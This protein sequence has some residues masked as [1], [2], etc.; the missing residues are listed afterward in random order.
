MDVFQLREKV[1]GEYAEYVESFVNVLDPRVDE[2]VRNSLESGDLWPDTYL[3]LNPA[4]EPG[5]TLSE[6]AQ[7]GSIAPGTAKFF[8]E[9]IRLYQHQQEALTIAQTK[10]PYVVTTGTGSGKSLTYLIP[11]YDAIVKANPSDHS[12]RAII[13]YPMNALINS[14]LDALQEYATKSGLHNIRFQKYTGDV[15][16]EARDEILADPPHILLTNYVMLE[17]MLLRPAER[18]LLEKATESLTHLVVDELHF[19]RGR[20]GSDVSM[21]L[22][23]VQQKAGHD[24]QVIGT[25]ATVAT[26]ATR[27][28]RR[29][30]IGDVASK[31]FGVAIPSYHVI[32]ETLQPLIKTEIPKGPA[33]TAAVHNAP[34]LADL[35]SVLNHPLCAWIERAFGIQESEN[36]LIRQK[37]ET[38]SDAVKRL[39]EQTG[40]DPEVCETRLKATL[41]IG[42]QVHQ[43]N[44]TEPIFAFRLHQFMSSGGSLHATLESLE[45]RTI[46]RDA[47]YKLDQDRLLFPLEF[48]RE[49]GQDYY[50]VSMITD[51]DQQKL[52]P[53]LPITSGFDDDFL[54]NSGFF[55][56]EDGDLWEGNQDDLPD[57][58]FDMLKNGPRINKEWAEFIPREITVNSGGQIGGETEGWFTKSPFVFCL[59]C[60]AV[61]GKLGRDYTKLSSLGNVGR[62]SAATITVSSM[63][64]G[65]NEQDVGKGESKT[66]SF[67]DN[68]QDAS[69]QAGHLNDFIQVSQI[70][71]ALA[72]AVKENDGL[73]FPNLG[74]AIFEAM[75]LVPSDFAEGLVTPEGPGYENARN[76]LLGVI[77]YMAIEDL[78]R[79]WR[80]TQPNLEQTGLIGIKYDGLDELASDNSKWL[81]IA[82]FCEVNVEKRFSILKAFLDHFRM[83]LAIEAEVLTENRTRAIVTQ[84]NQWLK[85]PWAFDDGERLK[86]HLMAT[87]PEYQPSYQEKRYGTVSTSRRSAIGRYLR[88]SQ[89]WGTESNFSGDEVE[90]IVKG[91]VSVLNGHILRIVNGPDNEERGFRIIADSL[92]WTSGD[93]IPV[94]PD[95]VRTRQLHLRKDIGQ[96]QANSYFKRLYETEAT[97]FKHII[98]AEHTGQVRAEARNQRESDFRSGALPVLFCS[99]TMELGVD[100]K[101]LHSVHMRNI[102]P[103]PANYAQR[104]GRAGRGG[105][106]ALIATFAAH[107]NAHD[108]YFFNNREMMI[109]GSVEPARMDLANKD[110]LEAHIHSTWL[111]AIGL[112]FGD[113][114]IEILD[115]ETPSLVIHPEIS[116]RLE[117]PNYTQ[118]LQAALQAAQE[119]IV[120]A[121]EI[122]DSWW[123][124]PEWID[125]IVKNSPHALDIAF[126]RWRE[127]YKSACNMR[128]DSRKIKDSPTAKQADIRAAEQRE[129]E[130]LRDLD[131][132]YNRGVGQDQADFYPYRYLASEG[133]IP[134]YNF[135]RLPVRT[136]I[137]VGNSSESIERYRFLGLSEFG[138]GNIVYHE[139]R[140]HRI[141][142]IV[143]PSSGID[144]RFRTAKLC[145]I[146]GYLHSENIATIELCEFCGSTLSSD[147]S[148]FPQKLLDQ[149]ATRTRVVDRISSEE[150]ERRRSGYSITTHF[151]IPPGSRT[152]QA[153]VSDEAGQPM[154]EVKYIPSATIWRINHGW[155]R[156]EQNG[157]AIDPSTGRWQRRASNIDDTQDDI[158]NAQIVTGVKPYVTD[159]R[160]LLLIKVLSDDV[161]QDFL[162]TLLYALQ[163]GIQIEYQVEE[164]EIS[165]ELIGN[166]EY[167]QLF[168]WESAEGGTGVWDRL[169]ETPNS[170]RHIAR[171][172]LEVCHIDAETGDSM[173]NHDPTSCMVACYECLLSY[174]NQAHHPLINRH[175][176][177]DFLTSMTTGSLQTQALGL[178]RSTHYRWLKGLCDPHSPLEHQFL[179]HLFY[180]GLRL[181]TTAQNRPH[182]E[183]FVQPDFYYDRGDIPG[184]CIFVDGAHHQQPVQHAHDQDVRGQLED[185]GFRVI[186][187]VG[188]LPFQDQINPHQDIFGV[189]AS[190]TPPIPSATV[191][192]E[193]GYIGQFKI[194][195]ELG[196]GGYGVVYLCQNKW[197]SG[198]QQAVKVLNASWANDDE[199]QQKFINEA[200]FQTA[201]HHPN[202][203]PISDF[204]KQDGL[205]YMVMEYCPGGNLEDYI[206]H[207]GAL[208]W[209]K[210]IQLL[211]Q[212]C[213]GLSAAH[214][215]DIIHRDLKPRNILI[216]ENENCKIT[217]FGL[218]TSLDNLPNSAVGTFAYMAPEQKA[219][220][221]TDQRADIYALGVTFYQML[222][223]SFPDEILQG[224][225]PRSP[226]EYVPDIPDFVVEALFKCLQQ[227]KKD[228]FDN[229][230]ELMAALG[231]NTSFR[232]PDQLKTAPEYIDIEKIS[233]ADHHMLWDEIKDLINE[234]WLDLAFALEDQ[235]VPVP[236]DAHRD[237]MIKDRVVGQAILCWEDE[238]RMLI[239]VDKNEA[240]SDSQNDSLEIIEIT[241][242]SNGSV[243]CTQIKNWFDS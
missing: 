165:A 130:A 140:K 12:V 80:V 222:T 100:I 181:P 60:R 89:T 114:M 178:T 147:N 23:R 14:Q 199:W 132:L 161:E 208:P 77:E 43:I 41:D 27:D 230:E 175:L 143:L 183:V 241:P 125:E 198:I 184:A 112:G 92:I 56:I 79:G 163:R 167:K 53:R 83:K 104:S 228:R 217:D 236:F 70:R 59:R 10:A 243:I 209:E 34:P 129:R 220:H 190:E 94:P 168:L 52:V 204:L 151:Q 109:S 187:I 152:R 149:P 73:R 213:D 203:V 69:L 51:N 185:L 31:L 144:E 124:G 9:N 45:S 35:D 97:R 93:G 58:W 186:S 32:D 158:H 192:D 195:S 40:L 113:S 29:K 202:V 189:P 85:K 90:N 81:E 182:P 215:K 101:E 238:L 155:R 171:K 118:Q 99:P 157:F 6:L 88:A 21:L 219:G 19:Y 150:E 156:S 179:D 206:K 38:V 162:L 4:F 87:L 49:C 239:L 134:G 174:S 169:I 214:N 164:Q 72:A 102:P 37:P 237:I 121:P 8:G 159:S 232:E 75:A 172:A 201:V 82:G 57:S 207:N 188:S 47:K 64:I 205:F 11:I 20:Q 50:L 28:E 103:N 146:C 221:P 106:P 26:G 136:M 3:Q 78:T 227:D 133:F 76:A 66:L 22:R 135:P 54:D 216:D 200:R 240:F 63:I 138:P 67:T 153:I 117:G 193:D 119:I 127:L 95:P 137:R 2:Y 68:R 115:L 1:V 18:P 166:E 13:V 210:A 48:C 62:S 126:N 30:R 235:G 61:Y 160:N 180:N 196:K 191:I 105:R 91:I 242:E 233:S 108:Q 96:K 5:A 145:T 120:R 86:N 234:K 107:G 229:C 218:A 223:N 173:D 211:G 74:S 116:Q 176:I 154:L 25:S 170:I 42:N 110:L 24:L 131:L 212:V 194:I 226:K 231:S 46:T 36:R 17:Y 111:G 16:G 139:G 142:G 98:G 177:L 15:R 7:S 122:Q 55:A 148:A 65:M 123:F 128:D 84:A 33:L 71:S 197:V 141:D 44:S 224:Q 39:S 225:P